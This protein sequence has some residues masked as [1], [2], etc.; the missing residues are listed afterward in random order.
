[1]IE[2]KLKILVLRPVDLGIHPFLGADPDPKTPDLVVGG[3][4][5]EV[6][7]AAV[8]EPPYALP[9][10]YHQLR[11]TDGKPAGYYDHLASQVLEQFDPLNLIIF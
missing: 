8:K 2:K 4:V 10:E 3:Y 7:D 11:G 5:I 9:I 1:M 6:F